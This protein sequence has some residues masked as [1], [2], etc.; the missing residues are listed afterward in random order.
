MPRSLTVGAV[1]FVLVAVSTGCG[2]V[3]RDAVTVGE[4]VFAV[5]IARTPQERARGLGE[6]DSLPGS[7]GMLFVFESGRA[8]TFWMKGMRFP[9]DFIWVGQDCRIVDVLRDVPTPPPDTPDS[10]IVRVRTDAEAVYIIEVNAGELERHGVEVGDA[11][12]FSGLALEAAG[13]CP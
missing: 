13:A 9:L 6:R 4:A 7:S 11:V 2:S 10:E 1:L 3:P 8:P 12:R 5:E